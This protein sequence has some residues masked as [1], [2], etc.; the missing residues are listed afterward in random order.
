MQLW[1][2]GT[3][4]LHNFK[5]RNC[6]NF[7]THSNRMPFTCRPGF[8]LCG[9]HHS[10][11]ASCGGVTTMPYTAHNQIFLLTVWAIKQLP[12]VES[13]LRLLRIQLFQ[14]FRTKSLSVPPSPFVWNLPT[15]HPVS[16]DRSSGVI[17]CSV[18]APFHLPWFQQIRY[19]LSAM[20]G[21][22]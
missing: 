5:S 17:Y 18:S 10:Y 15:L 1:M 20:A 12:G 9:S 11:F 21:V 16:V 7:M 4:W 22:L 3:N 2:N 14:K 13:Y 8:S 6:P 19:S